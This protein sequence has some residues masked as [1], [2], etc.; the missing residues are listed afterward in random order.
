MPQCSA[1]AAVN[2]A[3]GE[4]SIAVFA[5]HWTYCEA[6]SRTILQDWKRMCITILFVL[7]CQSSARRAFGAASL[8][9][10]LSP[11]SHQSIMCCVGSHCMYLVLLFTPE[12]E[13]TG[14]IPKAQSCIADKTSTLTRMTQQ[15]HHE[16]LSQHTSQCSCSSDETQCH[17]PEP[18]HNSETLCTWC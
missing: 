17:V 12:Q 14:E 16:N 15:H 7:D 3:M 2:I 5:A 9:Q 11:I 8:A 6:N 10:L 4:C 13:V 18:K 1:S